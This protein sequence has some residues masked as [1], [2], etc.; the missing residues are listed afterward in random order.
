[1]DTTIYTDEPIND[2]FEWFD[3]NF[4]SENDTDNNTSNRQQVHIE[5]SNHVELNTNKNYIKLYKDIHE[6]PPVI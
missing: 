3:D 4:D 5:T 2:E 6:S 1:M